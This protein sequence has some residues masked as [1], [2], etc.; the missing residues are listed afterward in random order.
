MADAK[1][2]GKTSANVVTAV[3]DTA[4]T[5]AK[6]GP[7]GQ[8]VLMVLVY[9]ALNY[10]G[11]NIQGGD[12]VEKAVAKQMSPVIQELA[13]LSAK[14]EKMETNY[15]ADHDELVKLKALFEQSRGK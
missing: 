6:G 7:V 4:K 12:I 14:V 15:S 3:A 10:V 13:K 9:S 5:L 2:T 11:A 8:L 1:D